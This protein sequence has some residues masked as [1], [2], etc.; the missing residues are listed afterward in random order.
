MTTENEIIASGCLFLVWIGMV[1]LVMIFKR[2]KTTYTAEVLC[3]N[4]SGYKGHI[5]IPKGTTAAL[6]EADELDKEC[7][8]CGIEKLF[9]V[10]V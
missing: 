1:S 6:F 10:K 8:N 3:L 7:P 2:P 5:E 9:I 4:C